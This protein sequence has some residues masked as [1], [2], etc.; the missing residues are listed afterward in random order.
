[1]ATA[2]V[3]VLAV[4]RDPTLTLGLGAP[5]NSFTG[6]RS[7]VMSMKTWRLPQTIPRFNKQTFG[8][9]DE[10]AGIQKI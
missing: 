9:G 8:S 5:K 10:G 3:L 6:E 7:S 2:L 1:M 4:A